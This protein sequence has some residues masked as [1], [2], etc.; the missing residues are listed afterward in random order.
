MVSLGVGKN[1]VRAIRFWAEAVG[2]TKFHGKDGFTVT[3]FGEILLGEDGF[4]P[5]LE[6]IQTLWL[7][8]WKLSTQVEEPLFAWDYLLNRWQ[9]PDLTRTSVLRTFQ[10]EVDRYDKK[11]SLVTLEQHFDTFLHTYTPTRGRKGQIQEDNLDCPL[12]ELE[13]IQK[14]GER[15]FDRTSGKRDSIYAFRREPKPEIGDKL[16]AYCLYDFFVRRHQNESTLSFREVAIGLG[17]PGQIFKL[18]ECDLYERLEGLKAQTNG[19]FSYQESASIQQI[20]KHGNVQEKMLIKSIYKHE[21]I[22][23]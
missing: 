3:E 6:D 20:R 11:R 17:S 15:E 18:P 23:V 9:E 22:C 10:R 13:L 1:M 7:I 12:V 19:L 4:D 16:F 14:I 2:V 5:Y 21:A 8:H